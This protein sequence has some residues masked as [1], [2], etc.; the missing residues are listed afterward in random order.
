MIWDLSLGGASGPA[1]MGACSPCVGVSGELS[2]ADLGSFTPCS[3][4]LQPP[5][6][7]MLHRAARQA[8]LPSTRELGAGVLLGAPPHV[9]IRP[10]PWKELSRAAEWDHRCSLGSG[11][12][13]IPTHGFPS[14]SDIAGAP[15]VQEQRPSPFLGIFSVPVRYGTGCAHGD[16]VCRGI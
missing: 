1:P 13:Q 10:Q 5:G 11:G 12:L 8:F 16:V 2:G 3:P 7:C 15:L 9:A 4:A 14:F 6:C